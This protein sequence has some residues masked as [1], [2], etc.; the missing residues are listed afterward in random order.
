MEVIKVR[1]TVERAGLNVGQFNAD[2]VFIDKIPHAVFEWE[3]QPD[4]SEKPVH[5]VALDPS[6]LHPLPGWKDATH[7]YELPVKDPRKLA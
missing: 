4:G 7:L 2:V 1:C 3:P 5:L 6:K